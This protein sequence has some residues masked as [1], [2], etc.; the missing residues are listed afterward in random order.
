MRRATYFKRAS[1]RFLEGT[2]FKTPCEAVEAGVRSLA[3]WSQ[4]LT[5]ERELEAQYLNARA[6]HKRSGHLTRIISTLQA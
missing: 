5:E 1:R 4:V 2:R 6:E 3:A